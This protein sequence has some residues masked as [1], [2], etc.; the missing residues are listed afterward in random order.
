MKTRVSAVRARAG[1]EPGRGARPTLAATS[2]STGTKPRASPTSHSASS[3]SSEAA[4]V[5]DVAQRE[6]ALLAVGELAEL[7]LHEEP[8]GLRAERLERVLGGE[9]LA[10]PRA[11]AIEEDRAG[12]ERREVRDDLRLV[13]REVAR[14]VAR[15][16]LQELARVVD[17]E[18]GVRAGGVAER[19]EVARRARGRHQLRPRRL[20][21]YA[22][23][24]LRHS[25]HST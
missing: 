2:E 23:H 12:V 15:V 7:L 4:G 3:R 25:L 22:A 11:R 18:V 16:E 14:V 8:L 13:A 17:A 20:S 10:R 24:G 21:N 5:A 1:R 19:D 9:L 6:L